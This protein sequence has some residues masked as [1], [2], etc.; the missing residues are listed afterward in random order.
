MAYQFPRCIG[1]LSCK[2]RNAGTLVQEGA[3]QAA[4]TGNHAPAPA[5]WGAADDTLTRQGVMVGSPRGHGICKGLASAWVIAF[6]SNIREATA[7]DEFEEYFTNFL[8]FQA[9]Y[10]KDYGKHIDTHLN[11]FAKIGMPTMLRPYFQDKALDR[12]VA[13]GHV[14]RSGHLHARWAAYLSVWSH[15][16][17]IGSL[18]G[19][20]GPFYIFEPNTGL[21]GYDSAKPFADDVNGYLDDRRTSK[22]KPLT[23]PF[24]MWCYI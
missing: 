11:Q 15:D 4:H 22:G 17:A 18:H 6:V 24:K 23:E 12:V 16:I 20:S 21:L 3:G 10:I 13:D 9:T 19:S 7:A 8:R 5:N 1:A 2:Y 14:F